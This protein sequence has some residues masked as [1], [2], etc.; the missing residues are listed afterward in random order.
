MGL[1]SFLLHCNAS[2][3]VLE[4]MKHEKSEWGA[5]CITIP[6]SK[7]WGTRPPSPVIYAHAGK[8]DWIFFPISAVGVSFIFRPKA[9]P[10][11]RRSRKRTRMSAK[12]DSLRDR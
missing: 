5:I 12:K 9:T 6:R 8:N 1:A 10:L 2:D 3:L 11:L 4:I 7:F